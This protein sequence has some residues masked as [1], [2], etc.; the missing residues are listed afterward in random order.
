[1]LWYMQQGF[2]CILGL[3]NT[4]SNAPLSGYDIPVYKNITHMQ[5]EKKHYLSNNNLVK[6][7]KARINDVDH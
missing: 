1:M 3:S 6:M 5:H 7:M 4:R 2:K